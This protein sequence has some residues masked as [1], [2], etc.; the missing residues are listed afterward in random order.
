[1]NTRFVAHTPTTLSATP[2]L[3]EEQPLLERRVVFPAGTFDGPRYEPIDG[4]ALIVATIMALG[5]LSV[6]TLG[7]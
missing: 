7:W 5:P 1:M 2:R 3:H 4:A 6:F